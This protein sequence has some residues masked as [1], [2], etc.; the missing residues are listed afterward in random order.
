MRRIKGRSKQDKSRQ[1]WDK[2]NGVCAHCGKAATGEDRTI[3]HVIPQILGGGNDPRNLMPVCRHC[4]SSR[5]SGEIIPDTY[6]RYAAPW[7]IED[8][9]SYIREWK[10]AHT[11]SD[12]S[13]TVE[14]YGII[15]REVP[16]SGNAADSPANSPAG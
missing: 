9:W 4:N 15:E 14:R 3:D 12:G 5:A 8:L 1:V 10:A 13:M 11:R 2:S 16:R 6:Y 7:A